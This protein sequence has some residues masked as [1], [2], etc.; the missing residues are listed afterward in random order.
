M[1][2][3]LKCVR[4]NDEKQIPKEINVDNERIYES[5]E[6]I[7]TYIF[8]FPKINEI[9]VSEHPQQN[10]PF[11]FD[12]LMSYLNLKVTDNIKF[13]IPFMKSTDLRSIIGSLD[14]TKTTGLD[15]IT[16]KSI[17]KGQFPDT[18]KV[19]KLIPIHKSGAQDDP[20]NYRPISILSI[21]SKI[22]EKHVTKHL[23]AYLNK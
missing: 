21:L 16:P 15:G 2:N 8:F 10:L 3:V 22:L 17:S 12:K 7:E 19:A 14:V 9:L 13:T 4:K 6:V 18:L 11:D 1:E 5:T 20:A 23:F